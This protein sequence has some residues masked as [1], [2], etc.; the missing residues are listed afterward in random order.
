MID[1]HLH[2]LP[3][4]DD[5]PETVQE[6]VQLARV[7]IREGIHS[8]IATP[9][10]NDE[11]SRY[12]A[13]EIQSRVYD[14]QQVLDRENIPLQLFA[15]HEVL[16]K[17]GMVE[18]IQTGRIATLNGSRYLLLE[19]WNDI[20]MPQTEQAIF[21]LRICGFIPIIAHPERNRV[22]Q[23]DST[24]LVTLIR[25]GALAQLTANGLIGALGKSIR[26]SAV[27]LLK[28]G[29]IHCIA[30]DAHNLYGRTPSLTPSLQLA[31]ELVGPVRV[32]QL[33]ETTPAMIVNNEVPNFVP[34]KDNKFFRSV[35][36]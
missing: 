8:A 5:G 35:G 10:Y 29:L 26:R 4:I 33:I 2:I 1:T 27:T 14:L 13:A 11:F 12:P 34:A 22:I 36:H 7:L 21:E 18:D 28:K 3:G 31:R 25:N 23:Q 32:Y 15:G 20:W 24:H 30:T 19:L 6:A 16:I 9:H 17:P